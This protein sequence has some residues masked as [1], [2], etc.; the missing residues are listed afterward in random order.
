MRLMSCNIR[1]SAARDGDNAWP[2]RRQLVAEVILSRE[3]DVVCFQEMSREQYL[4][5]R[6]A[7]TGYAAFA[8][9]D[10]PTGQ[11][12]QDAIFWRSEGLALVSAGGYWLS[13]TPH[14]PGSKS[15]DSNNVRLANW[16]RL[17]INGSGLEVRVVGTH[18]DH[19]SQTA[20]ENQARLINEDAAAYPEVYPQ[21]LLGDMNAPYEN[22]AIQAFLRGGWQDTYAEVHPGEDPGHTFHGFRGEA[23]EQ[24][25]GRIDWIFARGRLRTVGA[26]IVRDARDGRFPSDH[27]FVAADV[28]FP[29]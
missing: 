22:P 29:S 18:L 14:V 21:V 13:E 8:M 24:Q 16:V 4:Y 1:Y 23:F 3:P 28:E 26:E 11:S 25:E 19:I 27:Y 12:P 17:V 5:L 9:V 6:G 10:Q 2:R 15:W 7:L 20:R